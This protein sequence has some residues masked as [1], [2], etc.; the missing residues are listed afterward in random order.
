MKI[1]LLIALCTAI[2]LPQHLHAQADTTSNVGSDNKLYWATG[3]IGHVGRGFGGLLKGTYGWGWSSVSIK[4]EGG[5]K[6]NPFGGEIDKIYGGSVSYGWQSVASTTLV[7][8]AAGPAYYQR[9]RG[10]SAFFGFGIDSTSSIYR[11][12]GTFEVEV[13]G[14]F[15]TVGFSFIAG[16]MAARDILLP[17]FTFNLSFGKLIYRD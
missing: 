8:I 14:K 13:M 4:A 6:S 5:S 1:L 10:Q 16:L 15:S 7:R 12:G 17:S 3:G 11:F 9:T 2:T